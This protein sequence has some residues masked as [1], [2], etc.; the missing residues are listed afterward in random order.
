MN[1]F[2]INKVMQEI[3][4]MDKKQLEEG[5]AQVSK[6]LNNKQADEIINQIKKNKNM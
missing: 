2:D 5:M 6:M 4:K 1:N 3:N